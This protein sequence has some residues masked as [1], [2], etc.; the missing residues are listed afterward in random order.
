[1]D[2]DFF[3]LLT[4]GD[5]IRFLDRVAHRLGD[6][7]PIGTDGTVIGTGG[8]LAGDGAE[9]GQGGGVIAVGILQ[10]MAVGG[11]GVTQFRGAQILD[12][13]AGRDNA[14]QTG[15]GQHHV[16]HRGGD[17]LVHGHLVLVIIEEGLVLAVLLIGPGH[18]PI[19]L[20]LRGLLLNQVQR[21]LQIAVILGQ[22]GTAADLLDGDHVP[23]SLAK[24]GVGVGGGNLIPIAVGVQIEI[25]GGLVALQ[26]VVVHIQG[27]AADIQIAQGDVGVAG[28]GKNIVQVVV[29]SVHREAVADGQNLNGLA[30]GLILGGGR[31]GG[32]G[33]EGHHLLATGR[34]GGLFAG[35]FLHRLGG[36]AALGGGGGGGLLRLSGDILG[37][38][39]GGL[40]L[41]GGGGHVGVLGGRG[42]GIAAGHQRHHQQC[43]QH[44]RRHFTHHHRNHPFYCL[45]IYHSLSLCGCQEK[46][47]IL[48][49]GG[50]LN[51]L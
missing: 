23:T 28:I 8:G 4:G 44:Q 20:G 10:M 17:G 5:L 50:F 36:G 11:E 6:N 13:G 19:N 18:M 15:A 14:G 48:T 35:L 32:L 39:G 33:G 34:G 22:A 12:S 27:T 2:S 42:L 41:G 16:L 46:T 51:Y 37:H 45:C 38:R 31:G 30:L 24:G 29:H 21:G 43:R 3:V 40:D 26:V 7:V 1:M 9:P 25:V 49:D 47:A